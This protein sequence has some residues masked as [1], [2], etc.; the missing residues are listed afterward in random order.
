MIR[1][2][3]IEK[4]ENHP[5]NVRKTY[6]GLEELAESIKAKG[7]LQNLTVVPKPGEGD[8]YLVV[9]GNRRLRA[10]GMAGCRTL[11]CSVV[12]MDEKEQ[13]ETMLLENIQRTDLT[14]IEQAEGFQMMLD[15]GETVGTISKKTGFSETTVR[16]RIN[17]AKL[18]RDIIDSKRDE[19]FFQLS[20]KDFVELEKIGDVGE[21]NKVLSRSSNSKEIRWNVEKELRRQATKKREKAA[22]ARLREMG[23]EPVGDPNHFYYWDGKWTILL[24]IDLEEEPGEIELRDASGAFYAR[25]YDTLYVVRKK[26]N[27]GKRAALTRE[28]QEAKEK[29]R[30]RKELKA[31]IKAM[32]GYRRRFI[33]GIMDGTV[34]PAENEAEIKDALWTVMLKTGVSIT[35]WT[36]RGFFAATEEEESKARAGSIED[37]VLFQMLAVFDGAMRQA[38]GMLVD[39]NGRCKKDYA[40]ILRLG[41]VTLGNYGYTHEYPECYEIIAGTHELYAKEAGEKEAE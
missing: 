12:E 26:K 36:I 33:L 30:R 5:G 22:V 41:Y 35:E 29:D 40:D 17:I 14:L 18:D 37:N 2:I 15:L 28:E 34:E 4:L 32:D 10:A 21:R 8:R 39:Y 19:D 20:L 13:K 24:R 7:I 27:T 23:V 38:G 9:I 25:Q 11:P 3:E 6:D 16:H 31:K 1:E